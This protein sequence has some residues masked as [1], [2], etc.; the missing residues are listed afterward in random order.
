VLFWILQSRIRGD[1]PAEELAMAA[2]EELAQ[3]LSELR[4]LARGL[5]PA[6]LE[7]GLGA[8]L[9]AVAARSKIP[10][11]VSY[12]ADRRL[13]GPVELAGYVVASEPRFVPL[14]RVR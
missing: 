5:H 12:D 3:S 8:A 11:R 4:E 6:V 2:S 10:T 14:A 7:R 13:P 1:P 9:N